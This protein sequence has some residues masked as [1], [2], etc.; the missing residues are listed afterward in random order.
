M[1]QDKRRHKRFRLDV[2]EIN[3]KMI[4]AQ[5]VEIIDISQGGI[6]LKTD[7]RLNVGKEYL[8]TLGDKRSHIDVKGIVVRCELSNIEKR[9]N[10]EQIPMYAA[11]MMFKD[12]PLD[13]ITDLLNS[14]DKHKKEALVIVDRR[15]A[16]RFY[17]TT[18]WEKILSFPAQFKVKD[19]SL[20]GMLIQTEDALGMGCMIPMGLSLKADNPVSFIGK[21][22]SCRS[23]GDKEKA[24]YEI[25][26]EFTDLTDEGR[27][28]LKQF[29]DYMALLDINTG[30][31]KSTLS[32]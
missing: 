3:G 29:I 4:L 32:G 24:F 30:E 13:K 21:V 27:T 19:I 10:G 5:K 17:I 7:R 16:V 26:V 18:P 20:S 23:A 1:M 28:L 15:L 25:G 22:A 14:V 12:V 9:S 6:A 2:V 31:V 8:I 11:G